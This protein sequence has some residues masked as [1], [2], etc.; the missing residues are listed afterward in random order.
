VAVVSFPKL[1]WAPMV[2]LGVVVLQ[3]LGCWSVGVRVLKWWCFGVLSVW[4][5][6]FVALLLGCCF[7]CVGVFVTVFIRFSVN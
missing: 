4:L 5:L 2:V 3:V 1:Q 7:P 6:V